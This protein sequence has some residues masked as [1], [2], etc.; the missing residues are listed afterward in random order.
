MKQASIRVVVRGVILVKGFVLV[1]QCKGATSTF[2][3]GGHVEFGES[4]PR[5]LAR[6]VLEEI[7][8]YVRVTYYLGAIEHAWFEADRQRHQINHVFAA[9]LPEIEVPLSLDSREDHLQFFWVQ[10]TD[11]AQHNLLPIPMGQLVKQYVMGDRTPFFA[12]TL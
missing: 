10:P 5:A 2:L 9:S 3:P 12:S 7:G 1:A 4:L 11:L 6:E 8:L